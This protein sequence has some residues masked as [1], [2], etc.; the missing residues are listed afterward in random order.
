LDLSDCFLA[1]FV[2][3]VLFSAIGASPAAHQDARPANQSSGAPPGPDRDWPVYNGGIDGD[4]YSPLAQIDRTNVAQLKIAWQFD[5]GEKG[6]LE[7]NPLIVGRVLYACTFTGKIIA[8]DAATGKQIWTFDPGFKNGQPSRGLSYWTDGA[9]ARIFAGILNYLYALDPA[10]GKPIPDFAENGRIDL[11]KD[12]RGDYTQHSIALTT[13]GLVYKDLIVVGGRNPETH[14]AP[15][16]DIRAFDVRTG[17]L[18][19]SFHTIPHPGEPGYETWP[20]DAWKT[21]GAANNWAGMALD[22]VHG[23]VYAPTGSAVMDF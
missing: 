20:A 14:P 13:P 11:R 17:A 23:I 1:A 12:L 3:A 2:A 19:W 10:T 15:P 18:R 4:H 16:G 21:A 6:N 8:L 9:H 22:T 5:T 7:T